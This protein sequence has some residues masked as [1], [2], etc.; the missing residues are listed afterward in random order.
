M[1]G[2]T[3]RTGGVVLGAI[4]FSSTAAAAD[5]QSSGSVAVG[6]YYTDNVCL[7]SSGEAD[8]VVGTL[9]PSVNIRAQGARAL[10]SLQAAADYNS[11]ADNGPDCRG[12]VGSLGN[13]ESVVP[14]VRGLAN[15]EVIDDWL[16]LEGT[17]TATRNS[18]D[19]FVAGGDDNRNRR[20]NDNISWRY[21]AGA[22]SERSI[23]QTGRAYLRYNYNEQFNSARA[24]GDSSEHRWEGDIGTDPA[25][26]RFST[27]ITGYYSE[28]SYDR[29][30][31]G[32]AFENEFSSASIRAAFNVN[33]SWQVNGRIGREWN[34][35]VT[36][37][38]DND[39]DFW[40]I[41][42]RW[43]PN[44]RV[45][46]DAGTGRRFFGS[47]PRLQISYEHKRSLLSIGYTRTLT[48]PRDLRSTPFDP[49]DPFGPD[50]D[51]LPGDPLPSDAEPTFLGNTPVLNERW[52][53]RYR[54]Q[55]RRTT[56]T[57]SATYSQ[58]E[59]VETLTEGDF[60]TTQITLSRTL[61]SNL[62]GNLSFQYNER[63]GE[64]RELSTFGRDSDGWRVRLGFTREL[65][66]DTSLS[67]G[68]RFAKQESEYAG[69]D[70]EENR[71]YVT[72]RYGLW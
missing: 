58:Q 8:R 12:G 64:E 6:T 26:A 72:L 23:G 17:L 54:L 53:A 27:G 33:D 44:S 2:N 45:T 24:L 50:F 38:S 68:Y 28:V 48:I 18:I 61:A 29:D 1:A 35:Y 60:L 11:A 56:M 71:L 20:D 15:L 59:R 43:T 55:G 39:G 22:L 7:D 5:W 70:Y 52:L 30:R 67:F 42:V 3:F 40:D 46:V 34:E 31:L 21:S 19:P 63:K 37:R 41:G 25:S 66:S 57:L 13:R 65:G 14:S 16:M 51:F 49:D 10:L 62:E 36:L 32:N 9:R 69:N 4:L 47:S